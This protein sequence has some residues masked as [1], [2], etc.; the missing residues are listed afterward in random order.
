MSSPAS[1]DAPHERREDRREQD[2]FGLEEQDRRA[3]LKW[4]GENLPHVRQSALGQ[5]FLHWALGIGFVV[6]L[7]SYV[8]GYLLRS[9]APTEPIGLV[10]DLLYTMGYALWTG[11]VVVLFL[12]VIPEIKRRQFKMALDAYEAAQRWTR[13][14]RWRMSS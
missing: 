2:L 14:P 6:G 7:A 4:V 8:G 5:H 13:L 11:V 12:Q 10:A 3:V 1:K 9:S